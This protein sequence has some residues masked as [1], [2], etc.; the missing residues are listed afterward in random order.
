MLSLG[1]ALSQLS[2]AHA[3]MLCLARYQCSRPSWYFSPGQLGLLPFRAGMMHGLAAEGERRRLVRALKVD[4][5]LV[6][7]LCPALP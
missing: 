3:Q 5:N 4:Q 6:P 7:S 1:V 2:A